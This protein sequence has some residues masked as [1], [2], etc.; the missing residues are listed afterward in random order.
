MSGADW[1]VLVA[2]V[3]GAAAGGLA[4]RL[5]ASG[6]MAIGFALVPLGGIALFG[7]FC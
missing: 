6:W 2:F 4:W 7:A 1:F 5:P 3:V